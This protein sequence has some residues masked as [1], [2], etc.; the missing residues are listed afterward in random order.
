MHIRTSCWLHYFQLYDECS[1]LSSNTCDNLFNFFLLLC[2]IWATSSL[3]CHD[4]STSASSS[5]PSAAS[6]F[7]SSINFLF[8]APVLMIRWRMSIT[9]A[10]TLGQVL[11]LSVNVLKHS[12]SFFLPDHAMLMSIGCER[13]DGGIRPLRWSEV[14]FSSRTV[15]DNLE[16]RKKIFHI[17]FLFRIFGLR[18]WKTGSSSNSIW[19]T[20][21][22]SPSG[23]SFIDK[24]KN[25]KAHWIY[26]SC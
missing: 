20:S 24:K 10:S 23:E 14:L 25:T 8:L 15:S 13:R 26:F 1:K 2:R 6:E 21:N 19:W 7:D 12:L 9:G 18:S 17:L 3:G 22:A 16:H 4:V 11:F 5:C